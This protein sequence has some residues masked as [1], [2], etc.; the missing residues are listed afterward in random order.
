MSDIH[1]IRARMREGRVSPV[2]TAGGGF[3]LPFGVLAVGAVLL[4]F[5]VV[6]FMPKI[7]SV[8]RTATLPGLSG[9]P[10]RAEESVRTVA[11]AVPAAPA[12]PAAPVASAAPLAPVKSD[13]AGK[14]ADDVA[15]L[16]DA[17]CAQR[18][19]AVPARV[20]QAG[21]AG[22]QKTSI[23]NERLHCFLGEAPAR[24]CAPSQRRKA[25]ADIINYFRGIDYANAAIGLGQKVLEMPG[26]NGRMPFREDPSEVASRKEKMAAAMLAPDERVV[27]DIERLLRA[28]YLNKANREDI[29]ANVPRD[30]KARFAPI[31]GNKQPCPEPPWWAIWKR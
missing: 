30:Y 14:S 11:P 3:K 24:F 22:D 9:G 15:V 13:Y 19:A 10:P 2:A 5:G 27:E 29:L 25:T 4:G 8:Q 28:G 20:S 1:D 12:G 6:L 18:A 7:Y 21:P 16:A 26:P 31:V 17:V 23:A